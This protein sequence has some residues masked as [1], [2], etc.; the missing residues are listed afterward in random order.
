MKYKRLLE[1]WKL[2]DQELIEYR[3]AI[4][5]HRAVLYDRWKYTSKGCLDEANNE[6]KQRLKRIEKDL[7]EAQHD[8]ENCL[9]SGYNEALLSI[10]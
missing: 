9:S 10:N 8:R 1:V 6:L 4:V 3:D 7:K 5:K 2:T